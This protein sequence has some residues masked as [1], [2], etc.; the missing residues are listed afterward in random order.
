MPQ[1]RCTEGLQIARRLKSILPLLTGKEGASSVG[2]EDE[3]DRKKH[4]E[5]KKKGKRKPDYV[6]ISEAAN[7]SSGD[8][9]TDYKAMPQDT[10]SLSPTQLTVEDT[11]PKPAQDGDKAEAK[12]EKKVSGD[13]D[14]KEEELK[15]RS[16]SPESKERRKHR[17]HKSGGSSGKTRRHHRKRSD[18]DKESRGS[19]DKDKEEEPKPEQAQQSTHENQSVYGL[20]PQHL[21]AATD[22]RTSTYMNK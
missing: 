8:G 15:S 21:S 17:S 20:T 14:G 5:G 22:D 1:F 11:P 12:T 19:K 9:S 13:D 6:G 2:Q 10:Y 18:K 3:K 16:K 4:R 7:G